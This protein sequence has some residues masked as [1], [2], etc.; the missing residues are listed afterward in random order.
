MGPADRTSYDALLLEPIRASE[1]LGEGEIAAAQFTN[2]AAYHREFACYCES[3]G[4]NGNDRR[5]VETGGSQMNLEPIW[6]LAAITCSLAAIG[7]LCLWWAIFSRA[8]RLRETF[9]LL[10]SLGALATHYGLV[11]ADAF[12]HASGRA[13]G[14]LTIW[15]AL[16]QACA[17]FFWTA[18]TL[19]LVAAVARLNAPN[20]LDRSLVWTAIAS[21][22]AVSLISI[23]LVGR[24]VVDLLNGAEPHVIQTDLTRAMHGLGQTSSLALFFFLPPIYLVNVLFD[25][26]SKNDC[27]GWPA[28]GRTA[29]I[30]SLQ[31]VDYPS[32]PETG[33]VPAADF[34]ILKA[35][36][37]TSMLLMVI[38]FI[39][40][41][42]QLT[43]WRTG[44]LSH[45][46]PR[47]GHR[48]GAG[49]PGGMA[50]SAPAH[51]SGSLKG[52]RYASAPV[53]SAGVLSTACRE[54]GLGKI[55]CG[56]SLGLRPNFTPR[57]CAS[58]TP[59][60]VRSLI[61]VGVPV[62]P[63]LLSGFCA[64]TWPARRRFRQW[65]LSKSR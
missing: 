17:V 11:A 61:S 52:A 15:S 22:A 59:A 44:R 64:P 26:L 51:L 2:R 39:N 35:V 32:I 36:G 23:Y 38:L 45:D 12:M 16:G 29:G 34:K 58:L 41:S 24:C 20:R 42:F 46:G 43:P 4:P 37:I 21:G 63:P 28:F 56:E 62:T 65:K 27:Q 10:G 3:R 50:R 31:L 6:S 60:R 47:P 30:I 57:R 13:D 40:G 48:S 7:T 19:F 18:L 55:R 8:M 33:T 25:R 5:R 54:S 1:V 9:L 14:I 53:R 49:V